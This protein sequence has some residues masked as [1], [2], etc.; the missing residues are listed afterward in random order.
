MQGF[1]PTAWLL[2]SAAM[3]HL[4]I[5]K[6]LHESSARFRTFFHIYMPLCICC[7][8]YHIIVNLINKFIFTTW[9]L[10]CTRCFNKFV[11]VLHNKNLLFAISFF[12]I[13]V[14]AHT[15]SITHEPTLIFWYKCMVLHRGVARSGGW[16][17]GR[18]SSGKVHAPTWET[19]LATPLV[20]HIPCYYR[21]SEIVSS[22]C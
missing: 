14:F 4:I 16:G 1:P 10:Y 19:F 17:E 7:Y 8:S 20:L 13:C 18:S 12:Q 6:W 15:V 3:I 11:L 5:L 22:A 9:L 2:S 21:I